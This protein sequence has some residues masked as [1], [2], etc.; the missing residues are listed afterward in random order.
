MRYILTVL[1]VVA[2][3]P[4]QTKVLNNKVETIIRNQNDEDVNRLLADFQIWWYSKSSSYRHHL[5]RNDTIIIAKLISRHDTTF[6]GTSIL[7]KSPAT[8]RFVSK[9][10]TKA[11]RREAALRVKYKELPLVPS[12]GYN[13]YDALVCAKHIMHTNDSKIRECALVNRRE[14]DFSS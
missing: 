3:L 1:A 11:L 4:P 14:K 7:I 8:L 2:Q 10:I 12:S 5:S 9:D 13:E 6:V